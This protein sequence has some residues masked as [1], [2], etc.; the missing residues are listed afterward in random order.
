MRM[1]S[2]IKLIQDKQLYKQRGHL[3]DE[4]QYVQKK[5]GTQSP[6][7]LTLVQQKNKQYV[8]VAWQPSLVLGGLGGARLVPIA[9]KGSSLGLALQPTKA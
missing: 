8:Q 4:I 6:K 9:C 3:H 1:P 7:G 2:F 5:E